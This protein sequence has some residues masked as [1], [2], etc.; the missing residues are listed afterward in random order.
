MSGVARLL[1]LFSAGCCCVALLTGAVR[2][3]MRIGL[4]RYAERLDYYIRC[5]CPPG[6]GR[7]LKFKGGCVLASRGS[8]SRSLTCAA[9]L[10]ACLPC[11]VPCRACS[12][13]MSTGVVSARSV[14]VISFAAPTIRPASL[15][16]VN[17]PTGPGT[18]K[19]GQASLV[20]NEQLLLLASCLLVSLQGEDIS[21]EGTNFGPHGFMTTVTYGPPP[22][23]NQYTVR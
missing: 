17:S 15:R 10:P 21:F 12:V 11:A 22:K 4:R 1:L 8:P 5:L 9:C 23:F 6:I 7:N 3:V 2:C 20:R 18:Q 14:D 13:I 19:T 16:L